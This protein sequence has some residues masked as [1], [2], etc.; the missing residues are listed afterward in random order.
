[1]RSRLKTLDVTIF[2]TRVLTTLSTPPFATASSRSTLIT[3]SGLS[4]PSID[5]RLNHTKLE[6]HVLQYSNFGRATTST[7][8]RERERTE[9]NKISNIFHILIANTIIRSYHF[10]LLENVLYLFFATNHDDVIIC[11][12][13]VCIY[14]KRST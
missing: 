7:K 11:H 12:D 1:M 4:S 3:S 9:N 10:L 8:K 13:V 14:I 6:T 5:H 2:P